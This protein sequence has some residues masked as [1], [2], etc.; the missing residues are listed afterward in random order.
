MS[1]LL[2]EIGWLTI[3][4]VISPCL[5][6]GFSDVWKKIDQFKP[7]QDL[8]WRKQRR[9]RESGS[10]SSIMRRAY[11]KGYWVREAVLTWLSWETTFRHTLVSEGCGDFTGIKSHCLH[12]AVVRTT[13]LC[14][15]S[16]SIQE[17]PQS[18]LCLS[19]NSPSKSNDVNSTSH[20]DQKRVIHGC[21]WKY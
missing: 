19:L 12:H 8:L 17:L 1:N 18:Y 21:F 9:W 20:F 4:M 14:I 7:L 2:S 15:F 6:E 16:V 10:H 13:E 3:P 5:N 11:L